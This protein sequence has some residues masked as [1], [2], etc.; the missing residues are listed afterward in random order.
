MNLSRLWPTG[1]ALASMLAAANAVASEDQGMSAQPEIEH[2]AKGIVT[3]GQVKFHDRDGNG[4]LTPY[5]D[6]RLSPKDRAADLIKRMTLAEKAGLMMHGTPPTSDGTPNGPWDMAKVEEAI[7]INHIRFFI[8]RL[9][10]TP[11]FLAERANAMQQTAEASRL[12]IPI[13]F[14]SDPRHQVKST[15]GLSAPAGTFSLWP[16]FSGFGAIGD[17]KLVEEAARIMAREYRAVGIRMALSPMADLATE[18]RWPRSNGTFGD[19]PIMVGQLATAYVRGMQGGSDF[20]A[21]DGVASVVKHWVGY[22]AQPGGFDAHSPYGKRLQFEGRSFADHV[23]PFE[24]VFKAKPAGVMPT[25]GILPSN[26][27][28]EGRPAEPVG[29]AFNKALLNG[30]LRKRHGFQGIVIS[31]W[32]VTDDCLA[33]CMEGTLVYKRVGMPWGVEHLTKSQRF[34]KAINAGVDQFGGV[35]EPKLIVDLVE[36]GK[37]PQAAIDRSVTRLLELMFRLGLFEN[38]Y[39]DTA[40]AT[41]TV[42]DTDARA[43][44]IAAQKSS[45]ALLINRNNVLPL[46]ITGKRVWLRGLSA[47]DAEAVG[48]IPVSTPEEA[49]VSI[50]RLATPYQRNMRYFFGSRY[51]EGMPEFSPENPDLIAVKRAWQSGKPVIVSVYLD[52]PAIVTPLLPYITALM[53]DFGVEDRALLEV[54]AGEGK[55]EGRLPFELPS[56]AEAVVAQSPDLPSDSKFPAFPRGFGLTYRN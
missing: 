21:T 38:A 49:D 42:G 9:S 31:D 1:F 8:T 34:A 47:K 18:P 6:W 29:G 44:G 15:F 11:A 46:A 3:I 36:S 37:V 28:V 14:S 2:R 27:M 23:A 7:S 45:L 26:V 19:D 16:E 17:P 25:Y 39:V 5:E 53:G 24:Q 4:A 40:E 52:R 54:V 48:L 20:L 50:L 30:M 10:G 35:M 33:D 41:R 32:K 43:A 51:N 22:G 56:S 55:P 13:L 12:G